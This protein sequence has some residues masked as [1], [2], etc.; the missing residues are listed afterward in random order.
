[1]D[2]GFSRMNEL[3]II[4]ATQGLYAYLQK[5]GNLD[6]GIVIGRDHRHNSEAFAR[7]TAA[8]FLSKNVKVYYYAKLVHTP[9]V[10]FAVKKLGAACGIMITASHNPKNDNGYKVYWDNACQIIP[11]HDK[12]IAEAILYLLSLL[13]NVKFNSLNQGKSRSLDLGL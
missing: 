12:G 6:K 10:P 13:F 9:L 5:T 4:Q 8:V 11:P 3:T 7:L 2:A 1:M